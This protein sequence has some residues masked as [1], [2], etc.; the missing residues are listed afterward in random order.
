MVAGSLPEAFGTPYYT[1]NW[2]SANVK[3]T[4][5]SDVKKHN[6]SDLRSMSKAEAARYKKM[7]QS[8]D[9]HVKKPKRKSIKRVEVQNEPVNVASLAPV[10]P[11]NPALKK[12][13][14]RDRVVIDAWNSY[15]RKA[16][17]SHN[18]LLDIVNRY[19]YDK[20]VRLEMDFKKL[21]S[22]E[23]ADDFAQDA[24][25]RVWESIPDF[26]AKLSEQMSARPGVT[27]GELFLFWITTIAINAY[28]QGV[29]ELSDLQEIRQPLEVPPDADEFSGERGRMIENPAI[30][31]EGW[32][33]PLARVSVDCSEDPENERC[34]EPDYT[35]GWAAMVHLHNL[36]WLDVTDHK[37]IDLM[38]WE[39]TEHVESHDNNLIDETTRQYLAPGAGVWVD[40]TRT[41]TQAQIA[42]LVG[43]SV[44]AVEYR[45]SKM[46]QNWA[47]YGSDFARYHRDQKEKKSR[48]KKVVT[49]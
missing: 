47:S 12:Y 5:V 22:A 39:R 11:S 40:R 13:S 49:K 2:Y 24:T 7:Y 35:S 34:K 18:R 9:P 17:S 27:S 46:R 1:Q 37:I 31:A 28:E 38:Q 10:E 15:E 6:S 25:I 16:K 33:I 3:S 36:P 19:I 30:D 20:T 29:R 42:A 26:D 45:L 4:L 48:P 23:T 21:G 32:S 14:L 41:L 43:L 44:K 8:T